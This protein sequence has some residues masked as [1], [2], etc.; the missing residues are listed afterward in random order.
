MPDDVFSDHSP[1]DRFIASLRAMPDI[2]SDDPASSGLHATVGAFV[3]HALE[4]SYQGAMRALPSTK[5][6]AQGGFG[7]GVRAASDVLVAASVAPELSG[8]VGFIKSAY[9]EL[10]AGRDLRLL[11][12]GVIS[13]ET[14]IAH[15]GVARGYEDA[16]VALLE[17]G[18]DLVKLAVDRTITY[19]AGLAKAASGSTITPVSTGVAMHSWK[20]SDGKMVHAP[21]VTGR[22]NWPDHVR[23]AQ[24]RGELH[25]LGQGHFMHN[26]VVYRH[27]PSHPSRGGGAKGAGGAAVLAAGLG[28]AGLGLTGAALYARSKSRERADKGDVK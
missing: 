24:V 5:L 2:H 14:G 25:D 21:V 6:A 13:H 8:W 12:D 4:H 19:A 26:N 1:A 16:A 28:L 15:Q 20:G 22:D 9:L 17:E 7:A 11:A 27:D 23:A 3:A 10:R 18:G